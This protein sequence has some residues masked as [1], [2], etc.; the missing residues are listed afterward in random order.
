MKL[1]FALL[2]GTSVWAQDKT[3]VGKW[4]TID[5]ETGKPKSIVEIIKDGEQFKGR[6]IALLNPEKPNPVCEKCEG[7]KKDKP[8]MGMEIMSGLTEKEAGAEWGGGEILDPN[9]GKTYKVRLRLKE[10]GKQLEVRGF[11]G[12][13]L[14]GRSQMWHREP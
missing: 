3:V 12:F 2:I 14:L 4:K 5:D 6:I 10:E 1:L 9:N 7:E 11:I 13:S 8:I